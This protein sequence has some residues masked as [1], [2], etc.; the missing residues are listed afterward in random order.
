MR[1]VVAVCL[2]LAA[3]GPVLL[4]GDELTGSQPTAPVQRLDAGIADSGSTG[5]SGLATPPVHAD[6]V[7]PRALI[8]V[9]PI[10][11]GRCFQLTATGMG[12]VAPY[13]FEWDDGSRGPTRRVCAAQGTVDVSVIVRDA[14]SASSTAYVTRLASEPDASCPPAPEPPATLC[15]A[16]PSFEGS[17]AANL[18]VPQT[19]DAAPWTTCTNPATTP[20]TAVNA[21]DIGI[22]SAGTA[23]P[24]PTDGMTFVSI[25]DGEQV[26]QKLCQAVRAGSARSLQLDLARADL[27]AAPASSA[28]GVFLEIWGGTAADCS[29]HQRLWASPTLEL[30]WK[31]F[32]IKL[33]PT[34]LMDQITLRANSNATAMATSYVL[35]DNLVPVDVC[36]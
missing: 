11:C 7:I 15:I 2:L 3:C 14:T 29:Q 30:G 31:H 9:Q 22:A 25:A 1:S 10:D 13:Q 36:P 27:G 28:D 33:Q 35:V 12:G 34:E 4:S 17:P 26:S 5:T 23:V 16:N 6:A 19:F 18:G 8:A 21:P 24:N 32:C 20:S